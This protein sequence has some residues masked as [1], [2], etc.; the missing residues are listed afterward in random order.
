MDTLLGQH[1]V[2][3]GAKSQK[4]TKGDSRTYESW[5]SS[6]AQISKQSKK[7]VQPNDSK[8]DWAHKQ[9]VIR[10]QGLETLPSFYSDS[11]SSFL[12][13]HITRINSLLHLSV[14][15]RNWS[16]AYKCFALLI[17]MPYMDLRTIWPLG[18]EILKR[19]SEEKFS[20][21]CNPEQLGKLDSPKMRLLA[22]VR[23]IDTVNQI[24]Q[25][26]QISLPEEE[27]KQLVSQHCQQPESSNP[28][29][30]LQW[31][32]TIYGVGKEVSFVHEYELTDEG[33]S[34]K[35]QSYRAPVWR[36]GSKV[37]TPLYIT[38]MIL[39]MVMSG[40]LQ[41]VEDLISE[42]TLEPPYNL[43]GWFY[44]LR[45]VNRLF[46]AK[47]A[48]RETSAELAESAMPFFVQCKEFGFD[49]PEKVVAK[50]IE[51]IVREVKW[52]KK[53]A[54]A[55]TPES[56]QPEEKK[57]DLSPILDQEVPEDDVPEPEK[58]NIHATISD[59]MM[60]LYESGTDSD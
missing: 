4:P 34:R 23:N 22:I 54:L 55:E 5:K 58:D 33:V 8:N 37:H 57:F 28:L 36:S 49:Y 19:V 18:L 52:G 43:D 6:P 16:S 53:A 41:E 50:E 13:S 21:L 39:H 30:F 32:H 51:K 17:R 26:A 40:Q 47:I 25:M 35:T 31:L 10:A 11:R 29:R 42:M 48:S 14:L 46:E 38:T 9:F 44:Y 1:I 56:P 20:A 12:N 3:S 24:K 7:T 27:L 60:Q 59:F 15:R 45:G 2:N